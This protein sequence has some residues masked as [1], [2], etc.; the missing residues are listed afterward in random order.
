MHAVFLI[1]RTR[2]PR[3]Y[4]RIDIALY[5]SCAS[6]ARTMRGIGNSASV[7]C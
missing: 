4:R 3:P 1:E 5:R 2:C 6:N 7:V